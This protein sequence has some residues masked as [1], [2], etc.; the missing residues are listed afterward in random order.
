[1]KTLIDLLTLRKKKTEAIGKL[2]RS[3]VTGLQAKTKTR[4]S[5]VY[6]GKESHRG[7]FP[8]R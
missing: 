7:Y 1:M 8:F 4:S 6:A 5:K 3:S 2:L